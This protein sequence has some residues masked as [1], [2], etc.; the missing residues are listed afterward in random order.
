MADLSQEEVAEASGMSLRTYRRIEQ[1]EI[2]IKWS[3]YQAILRALEVSELDLLIDRMGY[4]P[5]TELDVLAA[6]RLLSPEV[7]RQL[8]ELFISLHSELTN[9][10]KE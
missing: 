3:R 10:T 5:A 9:K 8:V 7:R 4:Q 6:S 1:G 2:D